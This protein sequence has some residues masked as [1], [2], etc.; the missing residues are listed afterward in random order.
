MLTQAE[1]WENARE[2]ARWADQFASEDERKS[3][4]IMA[5]FW[6]R[7]ATLADTGTTSRVVVPLVK[8]VAAA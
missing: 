6:T 5:G 7:L 2:C 3:L 4:L 8:R 1:C